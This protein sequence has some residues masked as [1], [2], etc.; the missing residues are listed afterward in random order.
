MS[1]VQNQ[2]AA[3]QKILQAE[4]LIKSMKQLSSPQNE[5]AKA[6]LQKNI[7]ILLDEAQALAPND[8]KIYRRRAIAFA[9]QND[10]N[11]AWSEA[12]K[13]Q[14]LNSENPQTY[15]LMVHLLKMC[16]DVNAGIE[17]ILA[18]SDNPLQLSPLLQLHLVELQLCRAEKE[19][20]VQ[21]ERSLR[22]LLETPVFELR[23]QIRLWK[24]LSKEVASFGITRIQKA[25][26]T[27]EYD[28][29]A[30][31]LE[32]NK[33]RALCE[34]AIREVNDNVIED[35]CHPIIDLWEAQNALATFYLECGNIQQAMSWIEQAQSLSPQT[36]EIRLTKSC[37]LLAKGNTS[38]AVLG[39]KQLEQ[40]QCVL[41]SPPL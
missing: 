27:D 33:A 18:L 21:S 41:S 15:R 24:E 38:S 19:D 8:P 32:R 14:E 36:A 35:I 40:S 9:L 23:T 26:A 34:L 12:R 4:A 37:V 1:S 5:E 31:N 28:P 29:N 20:L 11:N 17:S 2:G 7:I 16:G 39:F 6:V 30:G 3:E 10:F 25:T 13:A 22:M